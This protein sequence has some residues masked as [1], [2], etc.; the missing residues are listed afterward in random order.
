MSFLAYAKIAM[1]L[2]V[3]ALV[4]YYLF[5][6]G[7]WAWHSGFRRGAVGVFFLVAVTFG[8]SALVMGTR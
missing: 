3:P 8:L 5:S 1:L 4:S 6:Y 2:A 7:L